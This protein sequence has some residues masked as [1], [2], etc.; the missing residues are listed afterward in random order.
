MLHYTTRSK[1][2]AKKHSKEK[3]HGINEISAFVRR[4]EKEEKKEIVME[5]WT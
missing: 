1:R 2:K 3:L 5:H 4:E